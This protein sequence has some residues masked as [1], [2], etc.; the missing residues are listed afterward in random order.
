MRRYHACRV[1]LTDD[2]HVRPSLPALPSMTGTN[3]YKCSKKRLENLPGAHHTCLAAVAQAKKYD[4]WSEAA[5]LGAPDRFAGLALNGWTEL[6]AGRLEEAR[7]RGQACFDRSFYTSANQF[8]LGFIDSQPD[9]QARLLCLQPSYTRR[10]PT[11]APYNSRS[12][13]GAASFSVNSYHA[14]AG[15]LTTALHRAGGS[16]A[17]LHQL[18]HERG[19]PAPLHLLSG[20]SCSSL[21]SGCRH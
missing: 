3:F 4:E 21:C 12:A 13:R 14:G 9:P 10:V 16:L 15:G 7:R 1:G 2:L 19:P 17:A 20:G 8:D 6:V 11:T 18:G 5:R